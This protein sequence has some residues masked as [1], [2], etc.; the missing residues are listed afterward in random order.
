MNPVF[1]WKTEVSS[2]NWVRPSVA[3]DFFHL[4][5][6]LVF[7]EVVPTWQPAG[8]YSKYNRGGGTELRFV[9]S[10]SAPLFYFR[11]SELHELDLFSSLSLF[12]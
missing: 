7:H 2:I 1:V 3:L 4:L 6:N 12:F 8:F 11:L 5:D 9:F 10:T